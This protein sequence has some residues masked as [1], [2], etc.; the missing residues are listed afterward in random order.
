MRC[1]L[2]SRWILAAAL[3]LLV[4]SGG[5]LAAEPLV[6]DGRDAGHPLG[7]HLELLEDRGARWSVEEVAAPPLARAF[8]P[9]ERG[10]PN[11][12]LTRS[13]W[14][15]RLRVRNPSPETRSGVLELA[16]PL[17]DRVDLYRRTA[18]GFTVQSAGDHL[19]LEAWPMTYR[20]PAFPVSL[21]PGAEE[22]LYLRV[23]SLDTMVLDLRWWPEAA[24]ARKR[25]GE[26]FA[27]GLFYGAL[28]ILVFSS[29]ITY[30]FV[31]DRSTLYF[32]LWVAGFALWRAAHDGLPPVLGWPHSIRGSSLF[33]NLAGVATV[34][35]ILGFTRSFL[36]TRE[37]VPRL[38]L[39]LR[40][41][42]GGFAGLGVWT[43]LGARQ[44]FT[45]MMIAGSVVGGLLLLASG[46]ACLRRG[47]RPARSYLAAWF[48]GIAASIAMGLWALGLAP[49]HPV[50]LHGVQIGGV[51]TSSVFALALV[52]RVSLVNHDLARTV[53]DTERLVE[54]VRELNETLEDRIRWRSAEL[55]AANRHKSEFLAGMSHELRTPLNA[56]IGFSEVL[57]EGIF[58]PLQ[59]RQAEYV[60]DIHHAG[61]HLLAVINDILELARLEA[62]R[63]ELELSEI[64]PRNA[65]ET[66]MA[67]VERQ[68]REGGVRLEAGGLDG[69]G[70]VRA[71]A[72]QI[73]RVI[74]ILLSNAI[75]FTPPRG[76]V[77]LRAGG[78]GE[79]W[80]VEI[81][82]T[83]T[84]V[85]SEDHERIFEAF[86]KAE[87]GPSQRHE[88]TGLGLALARL[89]V[90]AHGG[91]ITL[92]SELG[93]GS[94]FR[95]E[96]PREP[97]DPRKEAA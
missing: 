84:G 74:E 85:A 89:L 78:G 68:A 36:R 91:R 90:E 50:V 38:D 31:R 18:G 12:G 80:W 3:G 43:V 95:V 62:G 45:A 9:A 29:W 13:A 8:R 66:V 51:L 2:R 41:A 26:S 35:P 77:R 27:L 53:G 28:A 72:R 4:R 86:R 63:L 87:V 6:L 15:A 49:T 16:F 10:V 79:T 7:P 46:V 37:L 33:V 94:T 92:R 70:R 59:P 52:D 17:T 42:V 71:D 81:E 30:V 25:R 69:L 1:A 83:G 75:K 20:Q 48:V 19:P 58:G 56:V 67:R 39:A 24:F 22:T 93:A 73:G 34:L 40:L 76:S 21:V 23:E 96:I 54:E 97:G 88:G 32:G 47:Y 55:D 44:G 65:V 5:A 61:R 64:E 14:W 60:S 57:S 11:F 82:D